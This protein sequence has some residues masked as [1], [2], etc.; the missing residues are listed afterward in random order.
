MPLANCVECGKE[1]YRTPWQLKNRRTFCGRDCYEK[2]WKKRLPGHNKG[3]WFESACPVCGKTFINGQ[4]GLITERCSKKCS[5]VAHAVYG[6]KNPSWKGGQYINRGY[7]FIYAPDHP[8]NH[9]GHVK[10][11]ILT[12]EKALGKYLPDGAIVHHVDRN[13]MNDTPTNLVI[14]ENNSHHRTIHAR[15]KRLQR[16]AA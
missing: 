12:A 5:N 16:R 1:V 10:R 9:G 6:S 14:C 11:S 3:T 7:M 4:H 15:E 8:R 13:K 2:D